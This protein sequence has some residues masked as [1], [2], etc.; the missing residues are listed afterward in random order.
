[1]GR[2]LSELE[3]SGFKV[4]LTHTTLFVIGYMAEAP[5]STI[6]KDSLHL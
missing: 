3:I 1:M 4:Q 2:F 5:K 6:Q